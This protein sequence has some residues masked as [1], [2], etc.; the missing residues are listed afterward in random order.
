MC[1][2]EK[3]T[4]AG[5]VANPAPASTLAEWIW[6]P[7]LKNSSRWSADQIGSVPPAADTTRRTARSGH[8]TT[9]TCETPP[10]SDW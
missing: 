9:S 5:A 4:V 1:G 8:D 2:P 10:S 6:S 3:S 7:F